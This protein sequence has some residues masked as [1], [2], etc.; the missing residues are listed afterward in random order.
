MS[1]LRPAIFRDV[2]FNLTNILLDY[3]VSPGKSLPTFRAERA[4]NYLQG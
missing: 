1:T 3:V 2:Y 4:Y